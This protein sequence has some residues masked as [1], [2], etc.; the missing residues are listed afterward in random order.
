MINS[1]PDAVVVAMNIID[2]ERQ[3]KEATNI[4]LIG[5]RRTSKD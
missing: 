5:D 1:S 4:W 3:M 2:N